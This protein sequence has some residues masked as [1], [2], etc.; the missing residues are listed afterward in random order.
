LVA[1]VVVLEVE[2]EDIRPLNTCRMSFHVSAVTI[3]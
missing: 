1:V 2:E 3:R